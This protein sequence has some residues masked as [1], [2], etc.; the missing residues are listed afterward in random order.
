M[1]FK[2]KSGQI[3]SVK[4]R[5]F[6]LRCDW[7][8]IEKSDEG[9]I[10][11][12]RTKLAVLN[13]DSSLILEKVIEVN[14]PLSY[15][16]IR[17]YQTSYGKEASRF[18]N[19]RVKIEGKELDSGGLTGSFQFDKPV[20]LPNS[21]ITVHIKKFV[22]D[23]LFDMKNKQVSSRSRQHNKIQRSCIFRI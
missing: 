4:N 6:L 16:G 12:Y 10:K 18:S 9:K 23:F 5:S 11:D 2:L 3:V 13:P 7:F 15:K 19:V 20:T 21:N 22:S 14:S 8:D 1:T 17:F